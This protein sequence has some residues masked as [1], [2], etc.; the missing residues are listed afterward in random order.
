MSGENEALDGAETVICDPETLADLADVF[1]RERLGHL[2]G[3]LD[4]EIVLR[5]ETATA[6]TAG[7]GADAHALVSVSGTL[8]FSDLSRACMALERACLENGDVA[9]PLQAAQAEATRA[10]PV[11]A[12]LRAG[13]A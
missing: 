9:G 3:G 13:S 11:I 7:L 12:K 6:D 2:L 10:R 8:G 1:G 5:L 4:A